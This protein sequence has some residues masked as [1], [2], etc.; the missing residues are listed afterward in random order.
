MSEEVTMN[1]DMSELKEKAKAF[2]E[3]HLTLNP[4][5]IETY[6]VLDREEGHQ[7]ITVKASK[8]DKILD[9]QVIGKW[10][11]DSQVPIT[12]MEVLNDLHILPK[13]K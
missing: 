3:S 6:Y 9:Q 13:N 7:A 10:E 4:D 2:K 5:G 12:A 8:D 1:T 11:I